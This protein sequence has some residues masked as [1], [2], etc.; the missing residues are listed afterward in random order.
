MGR[1]PFPLLTSDAHPGLWGLPRA[2]AVADA[3]KPG[4]VEEMFPQRAGDGHAR[5]PLAR[6][7]AT[8]S[9]RSPN[10]RGERYRRRSRSPEAASIQ[11][12]A[13]HPACE[14][15]DKTSEPGS[16]VAAGLPVEVGHKTSELSSEGVGVGIDKPGRRTGKRVAVP[17]KIAEPAGKDARA[18]DRPTLTASLPPG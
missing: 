13:R 9:P 15:G 5:A 11:R 7:H 6:D 12:R 14:R 4:P 1:S 16:E 8:P 3:V 2:Q 10:H 18:E 17:H